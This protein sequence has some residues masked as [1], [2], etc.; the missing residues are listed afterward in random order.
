MFCILSFSSASLPTQPRPLFVLLQSEAG[1][2]QSIREIS[3]EV[4]LSEVKLNNGDTK[5]TR[6]YSFEKKVNI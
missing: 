2:D 4:L 5:A 6:V 3:I 1:S